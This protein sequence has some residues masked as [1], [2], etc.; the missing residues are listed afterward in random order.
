[1]LVR[2]G[3]G[4][5]SGRRDR[6]LILSFYAVIGGWTIAYA[7]ETASTGSPARSRR[8]CRRAMSASRLATADAGYHALFMGISGRNRCARH[9]GGIEAASKV[10]M[11]LLAALMLGSR[12]IRWSTAILRRRFVSSSKLDPQRL[13]ARAA[14]EALGLGFFSIG[15]GLG[16]DDHLRRLRR[17]RIDLK[18]VAV[19]SVVADTAISFLAGLAV[20]PIV[21]AHGLDP[22]ERARSGVRHAAARVRADAV[23]SACRRSRS[24]FC[25]LSPR[26]PRRFRC[27]SSW[28]RC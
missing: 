6:F 11:P 9:R 3:L 10:L 2:V 20:F 8:R 26:S 28:S 18:E 15:V 23:R 17:R 13:T 24:S 4:R 25:C 5:H 7:V 27:S 12:P 21:F 14:L 16:P 1:M 22:G 19:V